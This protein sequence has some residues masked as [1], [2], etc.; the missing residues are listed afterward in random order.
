MFSL[1]SSY[2]KYMFEN[3]DLSNNPFLTIIIQFDCE[4]K[5][6]QN[7]RRKSLKNLLFI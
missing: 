5:L 6:L 7:M 2:L 1:T 4:K 3:F